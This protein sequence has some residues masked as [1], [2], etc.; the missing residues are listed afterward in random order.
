M[1]IARFGF[2]TFQVNPASYPQNH[3]HPT[4][5]TAISFALQNNINQ[6]FYR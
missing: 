2:K 1:N 5:K 3:D 6:L 4:P